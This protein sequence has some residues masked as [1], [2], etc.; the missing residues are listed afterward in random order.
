MSKQFSL[1]CLIISDQLVRGVPRQGACHDVFEMTRGFGSLYF[2]SEFADQ[3]LL[4]RF[5]LVLLS[6]H[7]KDKG[8]A[9]DI[10]GVDLVIP[11]HLAKVRARIVY[12]NACFAGRNAKLLSQCFC[13]LGAT[14]A[15]A[16]ATEVPWGRCD[17]DATRTFARSILAGL[18]VTDA[19]RACDPLWP[20]GNPYE[21][22]LASGTAHK[23]P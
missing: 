15:V 3:R 23:T 19:V 21:A 11:R 10:D 2:E 20:V 9:I 1:K 16:P 4:G 22:H 18:D 5:D 7:A 6:G 8:R 17:N 13:V 12:L 14:A